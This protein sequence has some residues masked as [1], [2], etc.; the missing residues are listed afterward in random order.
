VYVDRVPWRVTAGQEKVFDVH[1]VPLDSDG[2]TL[3]ASITFTD[4]TIQIDLEE[5]L[6]RST[7]DVET[8]YEEL[9]STNEEL[10]TTNEELQSTNEELETTNE[11]LQSANEELETMNEELQS[12]NAEL[13]AT[14]DEFELRSSDLGRSAQF[15]RSLLDSLDVAV[16]VLGLDLSVQLWSERAHELWGVLSEEALG[17]SIF[18]LDIGLPVEALRE[19][20]AAALAGRE[21]EQSTVVVD[22]VDRRGKA[23]SCRITCRARLADEASPVGIVLL[24]DVLARGS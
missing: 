7:R 1:V 21:K 10:E 5:E 24:F 16:V 12:T 17:Q 11:E 3:G 14:S 20:I 4:V 18:G 9:Q 23:I 13:Q 15:L 19:P 22:A 6:R 2:R 8:A